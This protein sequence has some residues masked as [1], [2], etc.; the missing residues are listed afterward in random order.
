MAPYHPSPSLPSSLPL[1]ILS[2]GEPP[3]TYLPSYLEEK[4]S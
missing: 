4:G 3:A 2:Q 1:R